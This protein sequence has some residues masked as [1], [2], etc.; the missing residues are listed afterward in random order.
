MDGSGGLLEAQHLRLGVTAGTGVTADYVTFHAPGNAITLPDGTTAP[1]PPYFARSG[2]RSP[3]GGPTLAREFNDRFS[4]G[5]NA[6]YRR[7]HLQ[8]VGP[9]VTWEFPVLAKYRLPRG[10]VRP[11]IEIGPSFRT[12][13]NLNTNPSHVGVA[14]GAGVDWEWRGFR[15]SPTIR[16]TRWAR[17]PA[18]TVRS[19]QDQVE[20]L[21]A[22]SHAAA[23]DRRPLGGRVS[24]GIAGG[25]M[26]VRPL[27]SATLH[28]IGIP[29]GAVYD[30]F[31]EY[32]RMWIAGPRVEFA[33]TER[34]GVI[35]EASYRQI[36]YR[37][38]TSFDLVDPQ[39][40]RR[41]GTISLEGKAA[42][43]WQFPL[44]LRYA[45]QGARYGPSSTRD[46][47]SGC[48]RTWW[49]EASRR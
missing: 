11:F 20:A 35:A 6:I 37:E 25:L 1:I 39:G 27:R 26:L 41:L 9:T 30:S 48:R 45:S 49:G 5:T 34:L 31:R 19:K 16:Y 29:M 42:V 43:L 24:A 46:R 2:G 40:V 32:R 38:T 44:L 4:L 22:V 23:S 47:R 3:I 36:R 17:D 33:A 28:S 14:A 8:G 18:R 12:T 10:G 7:L 13:G 15:L 21:F